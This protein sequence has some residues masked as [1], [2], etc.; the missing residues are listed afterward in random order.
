[1]ELPCSKIVRA[2]DSNSTTLLLLFSLVFTKP[3]VFSS[4]VI[5]SHTA[6][7]GIDGVAICIPPSTTGS[8]PLARCKRGKQETSNEGLERMHS[9]DRRKLSIN[10]PRLPVR[11]T[12]DILLAKLLTAWFY[13][14]GRP[15]QDG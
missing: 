12:H 8:D 14:E 3:E 5:P 11:L 13:P 4:D 1:M 6:R 15:D 10:Q 7:V 2:V 9:D